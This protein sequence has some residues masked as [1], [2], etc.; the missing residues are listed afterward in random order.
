MDVVEEVK[1]ANIELYKVYMV[2]AVRMDN[3]NSNGEA[4]EMYFKCLASARKCW[5]KAAEGE[6][7]G[8]I[9][10]MYLQ[11]GE[12][13]KSIPYLRQQ[14]EIA[15]ELGYA[16]GRCRAC[17]SL[18]IAFDTLGQDDKALAE[19]RMV[20]TISE[21]A[22]DALLQ[23]Q[24]SKAL[25][26]LYSKVSNFEAA[27]EA[28]QRHFNL[29][30]A[31]MLKNSTITAKSITASSRPA[32]GNVHADPALAVTSHDLDLARVYVGVSKGNLLVGACVIS[33]QFDVNSLLDWKLNRTGAF[34]LTSQRPGNYAL[35]LQKLCLLT[36]LNR[37]F[38]HLEQMGNLH[39][40]K[41]WMKAAQWL[42][43][44]GT[45]F[46]CSIFL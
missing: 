6:A 45:A 18:A 16:E 17:S 32:A 28:F 5:D 41:I 34:L 4:L 31:I 27:V 30:K 46:N 3:L 11:C 12:A 42:T 7:N 38:H 36:R 10:N 24:A 19:L 35:F 33:I 22:G 14:S 9:G 20:Q 37:Y 21:Q 26:T 29:L 15:S 40:L 2:I 44:V 39:L 43:V 25:G 23:A 13:D 1:K 8:K